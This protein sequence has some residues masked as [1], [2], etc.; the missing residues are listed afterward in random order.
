MDY[1]LL[2]ERLGKLGARRYDDYATLVATWI[3]ENEPIPTEA[4]YTAEDAA[5]Q[6]DIQAD[7]V[8]AATRA[9]NRTKAKAFMAGVA[10]VRAE[11][12]TFKTQAT[13]LSNRT[14][15]GTT[16]ARL[17]AVETDLKSVGA[18]LAALM[19]VLDKMVDGVVFLGGEVIR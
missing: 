2:T 7:A 12:A 3:D 16:A 9:A 1:A 5:L 13:T 6:A 10:N 15:S 8:A 17:S 11:L 18:R 14:Y 4:E 19:D